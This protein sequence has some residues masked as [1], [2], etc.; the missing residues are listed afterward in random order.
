MRFTIKAKLV[1]AFGAVVV[2]MLIAA[3]FA[4]SG[5][6]TIHK[7]LLDQQAPVQRLK[8]AD[9]LQTDL[10]AVTRF[11]KNLI[12]ETDDAKMR[13][14]D[15]KLGEALATTEKQLSEG[16]RSASPATRE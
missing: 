5:L 6:A 11:E 13:A 7:T 10:L 12:I 14:Y 2:L 8:T 4:V 16:E 9:D 1:I 3:V 15:A